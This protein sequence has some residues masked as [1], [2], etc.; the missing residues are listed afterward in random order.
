M[1]LKIYKMSG[2]EC[3]SSLLIECEE[4]RSR[5]ESNLLQGEKKDELMYVEGRNTS[6]FTGQE[7]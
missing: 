6:V 3:Y 5:K 1:L 4:G 7:I 2:E